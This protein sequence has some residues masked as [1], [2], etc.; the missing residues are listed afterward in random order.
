VRYL[1]RDDA[2]P[3]AGIFEVPVWPPGMPSRTAQADVVSGSPARFAVRRSAQ[4]IVEDVASGERW[5]V[6]SGTNPAR[7]GP[8][9]RWVV[10]WEGRSDREFHDI[11]AGVF[12][13]PV[14][15]GE[16]RELARLW[17]ASVVAFHPQGDRVIV[18][19]R[20]R[21]DSPDF[22][23]SSIDVDNRQQVELARGAWLSEAVVS[24]GGSWVAYMVSLDAANPDA[25]GIWIVP[26]AGGPAT[27]LPFV[28]AY[29]WRDDARL[30]FLPLDLT[31]PEPEV[32]EYDARS[33]DMA[34]L[35]APAFEEVRVANNDWSISPDGW[36]MVYRSVTDMNL[37][38]VD[39]P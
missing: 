27:K 14:G 1:D 6:P 10:W 31:A 5:P 26:T 7:V 23:L 12:A 36:R 28:G 11:A 20:P 39:L 30:V 17:G 33:G 38:V 13:A 15:G 29:R 37:Y 25:N 4:A 16:P 19:G 9:G 21:S 24:P 22:V 35:L 18:T 2:S 34:Q 32:W 3:V 8:D